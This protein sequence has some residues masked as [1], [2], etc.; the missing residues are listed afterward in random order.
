MTQLVVISPEQLASVVRD[1]LRAELGAILR[2][3]GRSTDVMTSKEAAAYMNLAENTLRQWRT[4]SRGPAYLKDQH[5]VRYLKKD[6]DAW[7]CK[8]RT[9]TSEAPDA[10]LH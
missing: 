2:E 1:G 4:Q 3:M 5:G 7:L 9:L 8:S 6:I 10:P